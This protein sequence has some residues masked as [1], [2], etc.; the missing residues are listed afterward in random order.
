MARPYV[1]EP[2]GIGQGGDSQE[3]GR[4]E[5]TTRDYYRGAEHAEKGKRFKTEDT[6]KR[7]R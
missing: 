2:E 1:I 3:R 4:V 5:G 7:P 6:E